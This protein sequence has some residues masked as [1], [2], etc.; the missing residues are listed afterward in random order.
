MTADALDKALER[1]D[2]RYPAPDFDPTAI[3]IT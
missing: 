2:L 3:E 1:L